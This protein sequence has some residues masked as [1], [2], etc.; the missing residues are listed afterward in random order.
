M[1]V[2]LLVKLSD[3]HTDVCF[4]RISMI[5]QSD[6]IY[7]AVKMDFRIERVGT[8]M[9]N[10]GRKGYVEQYWFDGGRREEKDSERD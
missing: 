3:T 8:G 4:H 10:Y 1:N 5:M 6:D 9:R 2:S 7:K